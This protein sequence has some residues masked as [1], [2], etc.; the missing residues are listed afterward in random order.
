MGDGIH[1]NKKLII[2]ILFFILIFSGLSPNIVNAGIKLLPAKLTIDISDFESKEIKYDKIYVEN[3]Y[4]H[5]VTVKSEIKIPSN[6]SLT[7]GYSLIQ[8]Q[9]WVKVTPEK[10]SIP[11]NSA[12]YFSINVDVPENKIDQ[13]LN[14]N[15]EVWACFY[16]VSSMGKGTMSINVKLATKVFIKTPEKTTEEGCPVNFFLIF[17]SLTLILITVV[18]T[19]LI[20]KD[21]REK[22]SSVYYFRKKKN[23]K[24]D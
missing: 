12:G 14:K 3:P 10:L 21:I 18:I 20:K 7:E 2:F 15:W 22:K 17:S 16:E 4:D 8:D 6:K 11:A 23:N 24:E 13:F 19:Y 1:G 9:S 5:E